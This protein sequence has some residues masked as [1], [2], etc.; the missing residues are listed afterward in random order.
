M[1]SEHAKIAATHLRR[2]AVVYVRQSSASQL[3][4]NR[5]STDRQY[6]LV[7]RAVS[8]GWPREAVRVIDAD[9]G[10]SGSRD[11]VRSGFAELT[12]MVAL[13]QVGIVLALEV[14]R[15]ARSNTDWYRLLDLAGLTDTLLADTDGIYH[16]GLFNDRLTLGLKGTMAEAE[17]HV[18]R[19]RLDGGIRN[20][21]ERGELRRGLP[22][23]LI[24][25]VE[26]GEVRKHPDEAVTGVV[27]AIFTR[28]ASCGSVRATWLW[29]RGQGLSFPLQRSGHAELDWVTPTYTAVHHVLT[30]PAY[31]GAYA[32]GKTRQER[33]VDET[34]TVHQRRRRLAAGDWEVLIPDHHEGFIDWPAWQ[35]NQARI[36]ANTRPVAH[37]AGEGA[38]REGTALLQGIAVC[39]HCG[40]KLAVFYQ[41]RTKSTPGYY[42]TGTGQLVEGRGVRHLRVGGVGIDAAVTGAFLAALA[43]AGLQACLT[44]AEQLETG[45]DTALTQW[46]REVERARYQASKAE[47]RY[48]AVDPD[49]RLVARGLEADWERALRTLADAEAELAR[50]EAQRPKTLTPQEKTAIL[51]LGEDVAAVWDAATTTDRDRKELLRTLLDEAIISVDRAAKRAELTLRWRGGA[52]SELA[53]ALPRQAP[54]T[55]RTSEDTLALVRRL[56]VHQPDAAIAGILNRQG[57]TSARGQAFTAS[58]VSSLRTHWK[59]PCYQPDTEQTDTEPASI[60]QAARE[61]GVV[62]STVHRWINDGFIPAEQTTTGAPWRI[63]LTD[64]LRAR[65]VVHAPDG[66]LPMLEATHA[67]GVS[68]QTVLQRVKRG[69]LDAVHVRTG[70]RKGLRIRIPAPISGLF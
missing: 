50:R 52:L 56:A 51:A 20:K 24:W 6:G 68:R 19:A 5:E 62:P 15:L 55:I 10:M 11:T 66:Y 42:C 48:L 58:I 3:E 37:A 23:G 70:R 18:L 63:R 57:R 65:F 40:R 26:P 60:I 44:A 16:P 46:R 4:R 33:R 49:N 61:L 41:G 38:I 2:T 21:A 7:E 54:P 59:I 1:M 47:R 45:V 32:Y 25:G 22:V 36:G 27:A 29:L 35:A 8:L 14:S 67:L 9:L 31:A 13:G 34:G 39:G 69:E 28:F 30:N 12:S 53:V 17:L 64:E 43:P